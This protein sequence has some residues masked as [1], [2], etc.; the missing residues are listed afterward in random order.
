MPWRLSL[1]I[2]YK[3][4]KVNF[5]YEISVAAFSFTFTK[6]FEDSKWTY[7]HFVQHKKRVSRMIIENSVLLW[8]WCRECRWE[9]KGDCCRILWLVLLSICVVV[10]LSYPTVCK[11]SG[12]STQILPVPPLF[13]RGTPDYMCKWCKFCRKPS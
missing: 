3:E 11:L 13:T 8:R 9:V 5:L 7:F 2:H 6:I 4:Q 1:K 12:V 10:D